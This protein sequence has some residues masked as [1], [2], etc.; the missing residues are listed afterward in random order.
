MPTD[1]GPGL[2]EEW[3]GYQLAQHMGWTS[4]ELEL[5]PVY[6]RVLWAHFMYLERAAQAEQSEAADPQARE[7]DAASARSEIARA[8]ESVGYQ[9]D[10]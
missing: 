7:Q 10:T 8:R 2:P 3:F 9:G 4:E 1:D 5:C 6:R